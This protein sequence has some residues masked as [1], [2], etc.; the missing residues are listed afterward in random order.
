M[1]SQS[2]GLSA[3]SM[4]PSGRHLLKIVL[5]AVHEICEAPNS[6]CL[7]TA[8]CVNWSEDEWCERGLEG[9]KQGGG[10]VSSEAVAFLL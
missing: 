8:L 6:L 5:N 9:L 1:E 4:F 3:S 10:T 7:R 2:L